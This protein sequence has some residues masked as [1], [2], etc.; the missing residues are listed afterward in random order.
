MGGAAPLRIAVVGA[1]W[2]GQYF[3][4]LARLF[5]E[6]LVCVGVVVRREGLRREV[7][8][9]WAV[10]VFASV[11]E[12]L[13]RE[14]LD[15]VISCVS[16]EA[17]P[18]VIEEVVSHGLPV[19]AETPPAP[20]LEELRRLWSTVGSSGLVQ[21]A[22]QYWLM[23]THAARMAVAEQ[24][25]IGEIGSVQISSTHLYHAVSLIRG[26]LGVGF[27]SA[28]VSARRFVQPLVQPSDR[29]GWTHDAT[30]RP[31]TT[32]IATLEFESGR[33]A[34]YDF[35]DNQS[36][37]HLRSRRL[38]LRGSHGEINDHRVIRLSGP[39]TIIESQIVRRQTGYELDHEGFDTAHLSLDG[40]IL[41]RNPFFGHRLNDEDIAMSGILLATARWVRDD[42]PPP[43]PLAEASQDHLIGIAIERAVKEGGLVSTGIAEWV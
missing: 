39:E 40:S 26:Y 19:L 10:P 16:W 6:S 18:S 36:R 15:F 28:T 11:E 29:S 8:D 20:D 21:V 12:L 14:R 43:Y 38:L 32:T 9:R 27:E 25:V 13:D 34:L 31:V 4:K 23:P 1:G 3:V 7:A 42:G 5:P 37:N 33:S 22:E 17:N 2:R 24:G 41:W 35:T 30:P